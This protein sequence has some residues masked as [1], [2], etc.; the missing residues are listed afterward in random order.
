LFTR[1][2]L[3]PPGTP[4][5][6]DHIM[7]KIA[8]IAYSIVFIGLLMATMIPLSAIAQLNDTA[9]LSVTA[10]PMAQ[11]GNV[12][13]ATVTLYY[14]DQAT[15]EKGSMVPMPDNPQQVAWDSSRS[16]PGMYTFSKVPT[17]QWYYL[18]ADN[19]GNKWYAVFYMAPGTGTQTAN[20]HI[21]PFQPQND[22]ANTIS[23]TPT[24]IPMATANASVN[25]PMPT[26][27]KPEPTPGPTELF[28]ILALMVAVLLLMKKHH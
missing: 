9:N 18:E 12:S 19:N 21:P 1:K 20:V 3:F 5:L 13:N 2:G 15:G 25:T 28:S 26:I 8:G 27:S 11:L 14:Y 4:P 24:I 10:L 6:F 22:S 23:P 7:I 16:A 17:D